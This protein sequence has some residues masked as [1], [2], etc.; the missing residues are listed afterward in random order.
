M[1]GPTNPT[2]GLPVLPANTT[3]VPVQG[4]V[5]TSAPTVVTGTETE[6]WGAGTVSAP[7]NVAIPGGFQISKATSGATRSDAAIV[8]NPAFVPSSGPSGAASGLDIRNFGQ[9]KNGVDCTATWLA[10]VQ[11]VNS[12]ASTGLGSTTLLIPSIT[13]VGATGPII[14]INQGLVGVTQST[15]PALSTCATFANGTSLIGAGAGSVISIRYDNLANAVGIYFAFLFGSN[16]LMKNVTI[17]GNKSTFVNTTGLGNV[18]IYLVYPWLTGAAH[19]IFDTVTIH[20][21]AGVGGVESFAISL[22]QSTNDVTFTNCTT[23]N[24]FGTGIHVLGGGTIVTNDAYNVRVVGCISYGNS[25]QGFSD[26]NATNVQYTSCKAFSNGLS[27]FNSEFSV[28]CH[29]F[30]CISYGNQLGFSVL[31]HCSLIGFWDCYSG[32]MATATGN[33]VNASNSIAEFNFA[34]SSFTGGAVANNVTTQG[35]VEIH[36]ARVFPSTRHVQV[37]AHS[38]PSGTGVG[39]FVSS[40][41]VGGGL[42]PGGNYGPITI[43][44]PDYDSWVFWDTTAGNATT[45]AVGLKI[46]QR[47]A[48]RPVLVGKLNSASWTAAGTG[49]TEAANTISGPLG[50][51]AVNLSNTTAGVGTYSTPNTLLL[52]NKVYLLRWEYNCHDTNATW[53]IQIVDSTSAILYNQSFTNNTANDRSAWFENSYII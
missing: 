28:N 21:N 1:A 29:Y 51:N 18:F 5:T 7:N 4:V 47:T 52:P 34:A 50:D 43:D 14:Q 26:Y 11:A 19:C 37:L 10:A 31:G 6:V 45:M 42:A 16:F 38:A 3:A 36:N 15:Q 39:G 46:P 53:Q 25:V 20:D 23:F 35:P 22:S 27:G 24:N 17:D 2:V 13:P 49:L 32:A 12:N 48:M 30:N 8:V 40:T 9:W 41:G 44:V 33:D